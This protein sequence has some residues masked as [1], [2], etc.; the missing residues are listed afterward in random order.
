MQQHLTHLLPIPQRPRT[1][2]RELRAFTLIELLVVIAIIALLA[3]ISLPAIKSLTK[4]NDQSQ[5]T[6]LVRSL[7]SN[8]RSIAISQHRMAGVVFFEE[9]AAYS[10]PVNTNQTAMQIFVESYN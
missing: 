9:T 6:N 2:Q 4:N 10:L 5:S 1:L 7:I 3:G 8:A